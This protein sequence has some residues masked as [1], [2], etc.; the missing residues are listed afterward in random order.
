MTQDLGCGKARSALHMLQQVLET[1]E[2][3]KASNQSMHLEKMAIKANRLA[4]E[5]PMR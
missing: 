3:L 5:L 1:G 4:R 2:M